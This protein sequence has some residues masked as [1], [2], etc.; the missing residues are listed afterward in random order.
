MKRKEE[1]VLS[2]RKAVKAVRQ[3]KWQTAREYNRK[4]KEVQ[5]LP[6]APDKVY[7]EWVSW[8]EF[9]G[10]K[11]PCFLSF[12]EAKLALQPLKLRTSKIYME[13]CR[14]RPEFPQRPDTVYRESWE[15]WL[16]YLGHR[17]GG[18]LRFLDYEE[19]KRL[20]ES[21]GVRTA[22]EYRILRKRRGRLP[23]HPDETY[24]EWVSWPEFFG[25]ERIRREEFVDFEEFKRLIKL[26]NISSRADYLKKYKRRRGLHSSPEVFYS[27]WPGW[28]EVIRGI[29]KKDA[30]I[31]LRDFLSYEEAR[32]V[33][34]HAQI[35]SARQYA[36]VR[37]T[38]QGLPAKPHVVYAAC[39]KG[40]GDFL[41]PTS[42]VHDG[43]GMRL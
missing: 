16:D 2:Y 21:E 34:I 27:N 36:K 26:L 4:Y 24:R 20:V 8:D 25:R 10:R 37:R 18:E 23:V 29:K 11:K 17:P 39:W 40:W 31:T 19:A 22:S 15:G 41:C 13:W 38:I 42:P 6:S 28:N 9:F 3:A 5:G 14:Q 7:E 30:R 12:E 35:R 43:E 32:G 33:C 1:S